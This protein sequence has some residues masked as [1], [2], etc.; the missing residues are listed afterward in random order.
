MTDVKILEMELKGK[1]ELNGSNECYD[2]K[3]G[4]H[5]FNN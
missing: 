3:L 2:L 5:H 4:F 1:N